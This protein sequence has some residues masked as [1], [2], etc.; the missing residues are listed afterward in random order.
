MAYNC[1]CGINY[2]Y[3]DAPPKVCECGQPASYLKMI[4]TH[5]G[6]HLPTTK[7]SY[8]VIVEQEPDV[9]DEKVL[10]NMAGALYWVEGVGKIDV[11]PMG[12]YIEDEADRTDLLKEL[13]LGNR[14]A[15][16]D[17]AMDTAEMADMLAGQPDTPI[18]FDIETPAL[19]SGSQINQLDEL[20]LPPGTRTYKYV[21]SPA[22]N[23]PID[24]IVV[25][26]SPPETPNWL[27][28]H[29]TELKQILEKDSNF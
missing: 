7:R 1:P 4:Q 29:I 11:V 13:E 18:A 2:L 3:L 22:A 20:G 5:T 19:K 15:A 17:E 23:S 24:N 25:P 8:L 16:D 6:K 27:K 9:S 21:T 26:D 10:N 14:L 28:K 12:D